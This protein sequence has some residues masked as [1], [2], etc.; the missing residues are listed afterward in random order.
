MHSGGVRGACLHLLGTLPFMGWAT[1]ITQEEGELGEEGWVF[2]ECF[3]S[4][5]LLGYQMAFSCS[6]LHREH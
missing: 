2:L 5:L 3:S 4:R 6:H 1:Y